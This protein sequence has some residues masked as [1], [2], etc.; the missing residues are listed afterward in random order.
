[1]YKNLEEYPVVLTASHISEILLISKP[2]AY[3]IMEDKSFPLIKI[4]QRSKRVFRNDFIEWLHQQ[5]AKTS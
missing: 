4:G 5:Q 1:M 3:E 2:T